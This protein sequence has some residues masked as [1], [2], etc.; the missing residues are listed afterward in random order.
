[1]GE[2]IIN[3]IKKR[4]DNM[5]RSKLGIMAGAVV[6]VAAVGTVGAMLCN[7]KAMRRRRFMKRVFKNA[8]KMCCFMQKLTSF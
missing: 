4:G 6:A 3:I 7:S 1:M 2:H 5:F 8:G